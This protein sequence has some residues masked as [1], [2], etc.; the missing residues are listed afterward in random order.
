MTH[1]PIQVLH[2][3]RKSNVLTPSMLECISHLPTINLTAGCAHACLYCY[4]RGYSQHPGEGKITLY[5]NTLKKL[6][7]ELPRKRVRPLAVYFSPSS[8]VFQPVSE[9]L[10]MAYAV[11]EFLLNENIG[12]AFLTK[13]AIPES[14]MRL[15][16]AHNSLVQAGIGLNT[17]DADIRHIFEPNSAPAETRLEQ[18]ARLS[19]TGIPVQARIDPI[20]PG[21]TDEEGMLS[22]LIS[23][24][25]RAGT[26]T[27]AIGTAFM[28]SAIIGSL[29][30]KVADQ[31]MLKRLLSS[32]EG[33]PWLKLHR[34][35]TAAQLPSAEYRRMI[36]GQITN[37]A[38]MHGLPV[39][40]CACK[41][42]DIAAGTCAIA[43]N[44]GARASKL[45]QKTFLGK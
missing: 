11:F 14:H 1:Q 24:L 26:K 44:W 2:A 12:V 23:A 39:R 27:I 9:V 3:D 16:E 42:G 28:R 5:T 32:Y 15:F 10:D 19:R 8:D 40:I 41:N 38:A 21:V 17:L 7:A 22:E 33:G 30:R 18:I 35:N 34:A 29:K 20:L 37:I 13:G 6:R 25:H 43:G 45:A 36:Y 31:T 4:A